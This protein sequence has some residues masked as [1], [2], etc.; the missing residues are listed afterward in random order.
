MATNL[1]LPQQ[2]HEIPEEARLLHNSGKRLV[3]KT[4]LSMVRQRNVDLIVMQLLRV[5]EGCGGRQC[6]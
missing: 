4:E 2:L 1:S 3:S 6:A 5:V